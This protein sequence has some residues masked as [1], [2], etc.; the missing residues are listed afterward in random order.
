MGVTLINNPRAICNAVNS[1]KQGGVIGIPTDTVY[2]LAC[3]ATNLQA[4]D[5]LYQI[6]TRD[7]Q[8]PLAIC[9]GEVDDFMKWAEVGHLPAGLLERL[10]PGPVTLILHTK[11]TSALDKS[12]VCKGKV[13]IRIPNYSFIRDVANHL[14][15]PIALT[16]ANLSSHPSSVSVEE[17]QALWHKLDGIY[18]G[19]HLGESHRGASTIVDLSQKGLYEIVREGMAC[20]S[21]VGILAA[22][23]FTRK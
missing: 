13:G 22:F 15:A 12:L 21:T 8:K 10:L 18:D 16:S 9:V 11:K 14:Q 3:N 4:I 20:E 2:G 19:G 1:L 5:S 23:G 17:F 6:K 7:Y